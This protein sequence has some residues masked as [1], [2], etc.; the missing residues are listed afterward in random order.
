MDLENIVLSEINQ[1]KTNTI[2]FCLNVESKKQHKHK[3]ETVINTENKL[4]V[5][6]G[7]GDGG[8]K[9]WVREIKRCKIQLQNKCHRYEI[10]SVQ[11][12]VNN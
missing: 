11:N 5:T 9:K 7:E 12:I 8:I 2:S 10:Y 4:V 3:T 1:R 6:R